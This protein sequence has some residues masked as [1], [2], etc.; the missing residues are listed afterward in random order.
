[1]ARASCCG[2]YLDG[3][4]LLAIAEVDRPNERKRLSRGQAA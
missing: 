4:S 2:D 1:M 3:S